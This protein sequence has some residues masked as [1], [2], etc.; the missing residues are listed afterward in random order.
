MPL[1]TEAELR[2]KALDDVHESAYDANAPDSDFGYVPKDAPP[3]GRKFKIGDRE[4]VQKAV[5]A[6]VNWEF[7]GNAPDIPASAKPGLKSK[8]ASAIH[9]HMSGD[10]AKYYSSW[11]S[12][13]KQPDKKPVKEMISFDAPFFR[14]SDEAECPDVPTFA[15]IDMGKLIARLK[16][17]D[18]V[19]IT[20]PL[21]IL[22]EESRHRILY[23]AD[24][25]NTLDDQIVHKRVVARQGH[26]AEEDRD[27]LFPDDKAIWIGA[28]YENG[29]LY[30]KAYVMPHTRFHDMVVAR[31]ATST[32]LSTSIWGLGS[33]VDAG[34]GAIRCINLDLESIDFVPA[35]RASLQALPGQFDLT[36]EMG[37]SMAGEH[38]DAQADLDLLKKGINS[39]Q[40]ENVKE[41]YE[42]VKGPGLARLG[43]MYFN[44]MAPDKVCESLPAGHRGFIAKKH[45]G[46]ASNQEVY[47]MLNEGQRQHVMETFAKESGRTIVS[48]DQGL[49]SRGV[50]EM[51]GRVKTLEAQV[52][53]MDGMKESLKRYE[54]AD[55][56]RALD[57]KVDSHF[58]DWN[59]HTEDG[60]TKVAAAKHN[61]RVLVVAEMAGSTKQDDIAPAAERAWATFKPMA[62]VTLASLS[63]PNAF[64]GVSE[65]G[66]VSTAN[67]GSFG[68]DP[69]TGKYNKDAVERARSLANV[70]DT[71]KKGA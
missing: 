24:L 71:T 11:L 50:A 6:Y 31:K 53:E 16:D 60:K 29:T 43:E 66:S 33:Y 25:V 70:T 34:N 59:V 63:G 58:A 41:V 37:G 57:A 14:F 62:E 20:R 69:K 56:D 52:A 23:D 9:K 12:T 42:A 67:L 30:G 44:E 64:T 47:E 51:A 1:F 54:R 26:V 35:E 13:G 17:E 22:N 3:S 10:E 48:A 61:L 55:F 21:A 18:P 39:I 4:H 19:F 27:H 8:I 38:A 2:D 32:P 28:L 40:P 7:R 49:E 46:E 15:D 65:M 36:S 5:S 45:V 68:Y